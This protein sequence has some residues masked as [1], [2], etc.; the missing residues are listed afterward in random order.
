MSS[1]T[2]ATASWYVSA[3][4][5]S[6][7]S[8]SALHHTSSSLS[9][10]RYTFQAAEPK[11]I[12]FDGNILLDD[13]VNDAA[14]ARYNI[15]TRRLYRT[16]LRT[17]RQQ[18]GVGKH[19]TKKSVGRNRSI[20]IDDTD[21]W[22]LLQPSMDPRLY[23]YANIVTARRGC[24]ITIRTDS[25]EK[26]VYCN[27]AAVRMSDAEVKMAMEVLRFTHVQMGGDP[28]DDLYEYYLGI[29][30]SADENNNDETVKENYNIRHTSAS[31]KHSEGH[32]TQFI[33]DDPERGE[34]QGQGVMNGNDKD[35]ETIVD[36]WDS[37]DDD[38][39]NDDGEEVGDKSSRMNDKSVLVTYNDIQ[40]A[41]RI[42]FRAPLVPPPSLSGLADTTSSSSLTTSTVITRRQRDAI[43]ACSRL[44]KQIQMWNGKSS[45]SIN[46]E[47]GLRVVATSSLMRRPLEGTSVGM[48]TMGK[49]C[50]IYR[51]RVEN[52]S[53]IIDNDDNTS[54]SSNVEQS[55]SKNTVQLLGRRWIISEKRDD[56]NSESITSKLKRVLEKGVTEEGVYETRTTPSIMK[57]VQLHQSLMRAKDGTEEDAGVKEEQSDPRFRVVQTVNEPRTG[58]VGH[59]PVI[60][61]GEVFEYMSGADLSTPS[62]CMEGCFHMANV[63]VSTNT[64]QMGEDV[65]ALKWKSND[66]RKFE[67]PIGMFGLTVD[68]DF[69]I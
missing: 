48:G 54:P 59:F 63:D 27:C 2:W 14:M 55:S 39:D 19:T 32:Y 36:E 28:D 58:A 46:Q 38:D 31:G 23:G 21:T 64:S 13:S 7:T 60:R 17:C 51:I 42:A 40:N 57:Q 43:D 16:L 67:M 12:T 18:Y 22:I 11:V 33:D 41:I 8:S 26:S 30:C 6:A 53:D 49:Y 15:L 5:Q 56:I 66:T 62:G 35:A 20:S 29:S 3:S 50:Y 52:I 69:D 61:P 47:R 44:S 65:E 1:A 9:I 24:D 37:S 68:E 4:R 10:R 25:W 45:I 34:G